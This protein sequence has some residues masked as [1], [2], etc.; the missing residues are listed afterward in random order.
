MEKKNRTEA[1]SQPEVD[2]DHR[3]REYMENWR[4]IYDSMRK[5][6]PVAHSNAHSGYWVPTRYDD[7]VKVGL[8]DDLY[9]SFNDVENNHAGGGG[10]NIPPL[11]VHGGIIEEDP[12]TSTE[13][14]KLIASFFT[15]SK[16]KELSPWFHEITTRAIDAFI[17]RGECD[18][19][20]DLAT[21]V[22]LQ[23]TFKLVGMEVKD[24]EL[25]RNAYHKQTYVP[26]DSP[27]A[28]EM[29][30]AF[31]TIHG[32]IVEAIADRRRSPR[33]KDF[34]TTL[35]QA[36]MF[37]EP[38]DEKTICGIVHVT[39]AGGIDT[40]ANFLSGTLVLLQE[41]PDLRQWLIDNPALVPLATEEF[42]RYLTPAQAVARTVT[43]DHMLGECQLH[44]GDR[45]LVPWAAGNFDPAKFENP[46]ELRLDRSPNPHL[47]F[48]VGSH[49]CIGMNFARAEFQTMLSEVL[50]R[51]P[52]YQIDLDRVRRYPN[53]G[54]VNGV[55]S[56]PATFT[57]GPRLG[58]T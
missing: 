14:R 8:D 57:P 21:V 23:F 13:Q 30:E 49:R 12:P 46:R 31:N 24:L 5:A 20:T 37:G 43:T 27:E 29:V 16:V 22:P 40:T 39:L 33:E 2:F 6:C 56:A 35:C 58:A 25:Y 15:P 48:G 54:Q 4:D 41:R 36:T 9:S 53:I 47:A 10:I 45:M 18:F 38:L 17:E 42:L 26:S 44:A 32:E 11:E 34:V 1:T 51:M 52:D 19:V 50:R 3:S 55:I 28:A 7:L